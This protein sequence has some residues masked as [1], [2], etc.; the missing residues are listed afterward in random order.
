MNK[1]LIQSIYN[2]ASEV[3]TPEEYCFFIEKLINNIINSNNIFDEIFF[4]RDTPISVWIIIAALNNGLSHNNILN[5]YPKLNPLD[6]I[7]AI[8]Y[9]ENN[10]DEINTIL[11]NKHETN[12]N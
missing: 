1:D 5:K 6:L 2:I 12:F 8:L 7:V 4:I 10:K 11:K 3:L 9:Y